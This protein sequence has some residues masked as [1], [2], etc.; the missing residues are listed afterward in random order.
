MNLLDT[1]IPAEY[2]GLP[3]RQVGYVPERLRS[4]TPKKPPK[5]SNFT[6]RLTATQAAQIKKLR[7]KGKTYADIVLITGLTFGQVNY[8][9]RTKT[10]KRLV[11]FGTCER[12]G[13]KK[14]QA[15]SELETFRFCS[16]ACRYKKA[17]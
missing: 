2:L 12:C 8:A 1:T 16:N 17:G 14:R 6:Q 4:K 5:T 10:F 7:D 3:A 13:T 9:C 15:R 11:L